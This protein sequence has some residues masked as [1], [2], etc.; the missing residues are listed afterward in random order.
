MAKKANAR[1]IISAL[2]QF[3]IAGALSTSNEVTDVR[4]FEPR[5]NVQLFEFSFMNTRYCL[6]IDNTVDDD[7][8]ALLGYIHTYRPGLKGEFIRNPHDHSTTFGIRHKFHNTYLFRQESSHVRL[9][10]E[11]ARRYPDITRSTIQKYIKQGYVNLNGKQCQKPKTSVT[12][13]DDISLS[14]PKKASYD[15]NTLPIIYIDDNVVVINK[16][17]G[18]LTH[19]K[20]A[21][22][23]EFTVAEFLRRYTTNAL[24][25][26]RP[27]IVHRLDRQTSGII[28][29]ARNDDTAL[30]LKNQFA[31]RT[32]KKQYY[33]I[34]CGHPKNKLAKIDLPIGRNPSKPSTFRVDPSGKSAVTTCEVLASTDDYSLVKLNPETGRTHQLRVHMQYIGTPILGDT[35]YGG[36]KAGRLYLH[37]KSLEITVP[38]STRKLFDTLLPKEF[39]DIF[40]GAGL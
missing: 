2:R 26:T 31:S 23:D 25:T 38:P 33:A 9:D 13:L 37:A 15:S 16:P 34:I 19:S 20:G 3:E 24:T 29:G 10:V 5:T 39:T 4:N 7:I 36:K 35:I 21:L 32:T 17:A 14:P 12:E 11:L 22:S 30:S 27:G 8:A 1:N 28:I 40:P 6:I 18:V